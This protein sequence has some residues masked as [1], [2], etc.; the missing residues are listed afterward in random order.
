MTSWKP[1]WKSGGTGIVAGSYGEDVWESVVS[2]SQRPPNIDW[3]I[4]EATT[5]IQMHLLIP[6]L[7]TVGASREDRQF[8]NLERLDSLAGLRAVSGAHRF[9][10]TA[11]GKISHE[12]LITDVNPRGLF[13]VSQT[14]VTQYQW[15]SVMGRTSRP[16]G[17]EGPAFPINTVPFDA[18][19]EF[20]SRLGCR[21]PTELE[22]EYAC[23]GL[24]KM[25]RYGELDS[26]AWWIGNSSEH[27]SGPRLRPVGEKDPNRFGLF[28]TLGNV[29]EWCSDEYQSHCCN[30]ADSHLNDTRVRATGTGSLAD[31]SIPRVVRGGAFDVD[32]PTCRAAFRGS[33]TAPIPSV[34]F[35]IVMDHANWVA[36]NPNGGIG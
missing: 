6:S 11:H 18:A 20:C 33:L 32:R 17:E 3:V 31:Q 10:P 5:G 14:V 22:W 34:G 7:F 4:H 36:M 1:K 25:P 30:V 28:D 12:R 35:R 9:T 29:W 26:I 27:L 19:V 21:L 24:T 2:E 15:E 13:F 16:G 8:R 23:R